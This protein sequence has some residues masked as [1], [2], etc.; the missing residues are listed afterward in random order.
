M[1]M[2]VHGSIVG[3]TSSFADDEYSPVIQ[4]HE[5]VNG[6]VVFDGEVV[7][8]TELNPVEDLHVLAHVFEDVLGQHFAK[9]NTQPV[10]QSQSRA[11]E[12]LPEENQRLASAKFF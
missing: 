4:H 2:R 9:A 3:N 8:E 10:V 5:F 7:T 1:Q 6:A 12:H 11:V